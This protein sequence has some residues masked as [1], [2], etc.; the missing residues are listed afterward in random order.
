MGNG[1]YKAFFFSRLL[2]IIVVLEINKQV[3]L[4]FIY[5]LIVYRTVF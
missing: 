1:N 2:F 3:I 4:A 5:V